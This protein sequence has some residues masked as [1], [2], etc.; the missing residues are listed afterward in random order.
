MSAWLQIQR[1]GSSL[2]I[3]IVASCCL[4]LCGCLGHLAL[5]GAAGALGRSG[6]AAA[7]RSLGS[8]VG[9][10]AVSRGIGAGVSRSAVATGGLAT[11]LGEIAAARPGASALRLE[12]G[13]RV[14]L[15]GRHIATIEPSGNIR[16]RGLSREV[17]GRIQHGRLISLGPAGPSEIG[18]V[19]GV[20]LG[21][22]TTVLSHPG[23]AIVENVLRRGARAELLSLQ[24]GWFEL[25][26]FHD[27]SRGW[28]W[29]PLVGISVIIGASEDEHD[30]R[31]V[32][33]SVGSLLRTGELLW[34]ESEVQS[35]SETLIVGTSRGQRSLVDRALE[36][37]RFSA[38]S[39]AE[40]DW[41]KDLRPVRLRSGA[42]VSV[43]DCRLVREVAYLDF[44]GPG[45]G[46]PSWP[47]ARVV[48]DSRLV[49]S[50][51]RD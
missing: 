31:G 43:K 29:A 12:P 51:C 32:A 50:G 4:L 5:R 21:T 10:G 16:G 26:F 14:R 13:G 11:V 19:H 34:V 8:A 39:H 36:D 25:R 41:S 42:Q 24:N 48:V 46:L 7:G 2:R 3:I 6:A 28:V 33:A 35:G 17:I 40:V 47:G 45:D 22:R 37:G 20:F 44:L 1:R 38:S 9:R 23:G 18:R 27:G 15:H 30:D 49:D